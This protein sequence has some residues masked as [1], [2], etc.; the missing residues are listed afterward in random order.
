MIAASVLRLTLLL[1]WLVAPQ[2]TQPERLFHSRDRS[3][4]E[5]SPLSRAKPIA[6]LHAAQVRGDAESSSICT[7]THTIHYTCTQTC[8]E[9]RT[10]HGRI[11]V[12]RQR[13]CFVKLGMKPG[14]LCMLGNHLSHGMALPSSPT[15]WL[16]SILPLQGPCGTH[17]STLVDPGYRPF[18]SSFTL[19]IS[20]LFPASTA[21]EKSQQEAT[22]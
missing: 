10:Y 4:L 20:C 9:T 17:D 1:C 12:Q 2:P 11:A 14:A 13:A 15:T 5:P 18:I 21:Q 6:D 22:L 19:C 3:D 7:H 16:A 8:V